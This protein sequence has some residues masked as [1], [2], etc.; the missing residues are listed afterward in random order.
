VPLPIFLQVP[1]PIFASDWHFYHWLL[2]FSVQWIVVS[3][4]SDPSQP[5]PWLRRHRLR[6]L[7]IGNGVAMG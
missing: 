7:A 5:E 1:V 6:L 2:G 4:S 3:S